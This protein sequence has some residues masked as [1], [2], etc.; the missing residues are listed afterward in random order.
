MATR[1]PSPARA[2]PDKRRTGERRC[3]MNFQQ[4][5]LYWLAGAVLLVVAIMSWR[6]KSNP[7]GV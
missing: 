1:S 4:T 3:G 5:Y 2:G 7:R 6:D